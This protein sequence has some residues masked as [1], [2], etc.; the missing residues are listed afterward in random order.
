MTNW[1]SVEPLPWLG[2]LIETSRERVASV[3]SVALSRTGK[4]SAHQ[5]KPIPAFFDCQRCA[6]VQTTHPDI[7]ST[8]ISCFFPRFSSIGF[9][10]YHSCARSIAYSEQPLHSVDTRKKQYGGSYELHRSSSRHIATAHAFFR[11]STRCQCA[12]QTSRE[13]VRFGEGRSTPS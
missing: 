6:E 1:I 13:R 7:C 4:A 10:L 8:I 9:P 3:A 2:V 5:P 12:C 11:G